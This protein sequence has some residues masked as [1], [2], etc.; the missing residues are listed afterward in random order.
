MTISSVG[1]DKIGLIIDVIFNR[2]NVGLIEKL[3]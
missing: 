2:L 3:I 1:P